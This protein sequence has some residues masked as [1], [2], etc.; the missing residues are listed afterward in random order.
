ML[1]PQ[2]LHQLK[3]RHCFREP[4]GVRLVQAWSSLP[5][6]FVSGLASLSTFY[7]TGAQQLKQII[8]A[9]RKRV[10][11]ITQIAVTQMWS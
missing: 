6:I 7:Y 1:L 4:I 8:Q 5:L 9:R 3:K 2:N 10:Y 11:S